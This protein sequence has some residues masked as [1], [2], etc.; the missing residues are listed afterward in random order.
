MSKAVT[1]GAVVI[2]IAG[3]IWY[4]A[5]RPSS[6]A[7]PDTGTPST[8]SQTNT[9]TDTSDAQLQVD[10]NASDAQIQSATEA[11]VNANTFNDTPVTQTE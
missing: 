1:W 6:G 5:T 3:G 4:F 7:A 2:I 8:A 11:G 10:L 9:S